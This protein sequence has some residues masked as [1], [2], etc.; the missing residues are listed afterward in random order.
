M[1][2]LPPKKTLPENWYSVA[3]ERMTRIRKLEARNKEL[4]EKRDSSRRAIR[5]CSKACFELS[6]RNKELV[7][8]LEVIVVQEK[9]CSF[10]N[11]S[12]TLQ[13]IG[14]I[15]RQALAKEPSDG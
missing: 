8:A 11:T 1:R 14:R 9:V 6:K 15:A 13:G 5:K 2:K 12:R 10:E 7:V 4:E 3:A